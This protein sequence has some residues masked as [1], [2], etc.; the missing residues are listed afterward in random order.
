MKTPDKCISIFHIAIFDIQAERGRQMQSVESSL[1]SLSVT[2]DD[3]AFKENQRDRL[4]RNGLPSLVLAIFSCS[5]RTNL[6]T[7]L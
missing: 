7:I 1:A 2:Q 6:I 3:Y 5:T 4:V